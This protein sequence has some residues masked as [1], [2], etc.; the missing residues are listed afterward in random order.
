[1]PHHARLLTRITRPWGG[2]G[3]A[4]EG[5]N[6][7]VI[8]RMHHHHSRCRSDLH[9]RAA[10]GPPPA[11]RPALAATESTYPPPSSCYRCLVYPLA[12]PPRAAPHLPTSARFCRGSVR[13]GDLHHKGVSKPEVVTCGA[14]PKRGLPNDHCASLDNTSCASSADKGNNWS[15]PCRV[16]RLVSAKGREEPPHWRRC[17]CSRRQQ[18]S[19]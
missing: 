4:Q 9:P 2:R 7:C 5:C 15:L 3:W 13:G 1:M 10:P 19:P 8:L 16:G 18:A 11:R 6:A 17:R 12:R 14:L